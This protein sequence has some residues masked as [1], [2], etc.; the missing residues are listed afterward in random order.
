MS[1]RE[2]ALGKSDRNAQVTLS[3]RQPRERFSSQ[4]E[5]VERK[6]VNAECRFSRMHCEGTWTSRMKNPVKF[7]QPRTCRPKTPRLSLRPT[8]LQPFCHTPCVVPVSHDRQSLASVLDSTAS[9]DLDM[10]RFRYSGWSFERGRT[11]SYSPHGLPRTCSISKIVRSRG[12]G[13]QQ[14]TCL[15]TTAA[16]LFGPQTNRSPS[17]VYTFPWPPAVGGYRRVCPLLPQKKGV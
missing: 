14:S 4:S 13:Q 17:R 16:P 3:A 6:R 11:D 2:R 9:C 5:S 7:V 15:D 8:A 10:H 12:L 1:T